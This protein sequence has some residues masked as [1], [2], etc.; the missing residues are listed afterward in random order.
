MNEVWSQAE[1]EFCYLLADYTCFCLVHKRVS[2]FGRNIGGIC[3]YVHD[4]IVKY[5]SRICK[6]ATDCIFLYSDK[7]VDYLMITSFLPLLIF[8]LRREKIKLEKM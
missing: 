1:S 4:S 2:N 3:V 6:H 7:R 8:S 5:F